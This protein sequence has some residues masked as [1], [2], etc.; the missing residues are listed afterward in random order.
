MTHHHSF[1]CAVFARCSSHSDRLDQHLKSW[2][3]FC[4]SLARS[5]FSWSGATFALLGDTGVAW[6]AVNVIFTLQ[7]RQRRFR[8][9]LPYLLN[10]VTPLL[11]R[12]L[13]DPPWIDLRPCADFFGDVNTV[14][15]CHEAWDQLGDVPAIDGLFSLKWSPRKFDNIWDFGPTAI[16]GLSKVWNPDLQVLMGSMSHSSMGLSTTTVCTLSLHCTAP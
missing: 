12:R 14:L 7:W 6:R 3:L 15:S 4:S 5:Y 8:N 13:P 2:F 10:R 16:F 1:S 9:Q 11:D